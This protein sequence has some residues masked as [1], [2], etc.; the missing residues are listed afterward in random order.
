MS[1][2]GSLFTR[3]AKCDAD[4]RAAQALRYCVFGQELGAKGASFDV[5]QGLEQ[6]IFDAVS[7]HLLLIDVSRSVGDQIVGVYR[8]MGAAGAIAAGSYYSESEFDI[9]VLKASGRKLLELGRSC[10]HRDYRGSG[11]IYLMWQAISQYVAENRYEILFGTASFS[12]TD[13]KS[14]A[15]S[16]GELM[17]NFLAKQDMRPTALS[18]DVE[19]LAPAALDRRRA[20]R[21]MPPM[22]KAYLRL[23]GLVGQGIFIDEGFNTTDV[24]L[25]L[26]TDLVPVKQKEMFS[27]SRAVA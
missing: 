24:L 7:Q 2:Q 3:W 27:K 19:F 20:M 9:S 23:G 12:G 17:N 10:I 21:D 6:D 1:P 26:D 18:A 11:A 22:I 8:V 16:L 14:F 4:I 25:V 15:H 5:E 13:P